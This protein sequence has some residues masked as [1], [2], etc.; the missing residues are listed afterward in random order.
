MLLAQ[1][2][3]AR[4]DYAEAARV[5]AAFDHQEPA[6]FLAYVPASLQIR[7]A[8]ARGM[9]EERAAAGFEARLAAIARAAKEAQER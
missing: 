8:S 1:V 6:A 2:L 5:A 7:A 3:L 9:G 4:R